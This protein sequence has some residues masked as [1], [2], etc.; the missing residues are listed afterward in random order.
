MAFE[1]ERLTGARG[2]MDARCRVDGGDPEHGD[3]VASEE[4][5]RLRS[6][7]IR[8]SMPVASRPI[9]IGATVESIIAWTAGRQ[10]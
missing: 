4:V 5:Q 3:A 6:S 8:V 10:S 7:R 1:R 9:R 2:T